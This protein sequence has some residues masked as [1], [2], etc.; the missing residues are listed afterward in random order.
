[1]GSE[2]AT[3]RTRSANRRCID[4]KTATKGSMVAFGFVPGDEGHLQGEVL[5]HGHAGTT[6]DA[7]EGFQAGWA[8]GITAD[9]RQGRYGSVNM[10]TK[11]RD[12]PVCCDRLRAEPGMKI[13]LKQEDS[14][15]AG[16][17][18]YIM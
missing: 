16:H 11:S 9:G 5:G 1:M 6:F 7:H 18:Q 4:M 17:W 12:E 2:W 15:R 14:L 10:R 3:G 8:S 13:S